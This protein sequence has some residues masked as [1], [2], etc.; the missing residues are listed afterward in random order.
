MSVEVKVSDPPAVAPTPVALPIVAPPRPDWLDRWLHI[1]EA[2]DSMRVIPRIVLGAVVTL[3]FWYIV[4]TTIWYMQ[5]TIEGRT[6]NVTM[7]IGGGLGILSGL[8]G[9]VYKI[10]AGGGRDWD[11]QQNT[12]QGPRQ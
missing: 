12:Q 9:L 2:V 1:S 7:Y 6:G 4:V 10:Y 11:G 3:T 8:F 5:L